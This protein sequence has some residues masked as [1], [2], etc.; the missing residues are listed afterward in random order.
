MERSIDKIISEAMKQGKFDNLPGSGK[1][2][3]RDENDTTP[4]ELRMAFTVLKN[5]GYV[6]VE[7][8]WLREIDA[9]SDR[10]ARTTDP[11]ERGRLTREIQQLKLKVSLFLEGL[12]G[13]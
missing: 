13:G 10:L 7:A 5:A 11:E 3:P 1:P 8:E 4:A 6:P 12:R 9:L 2:L